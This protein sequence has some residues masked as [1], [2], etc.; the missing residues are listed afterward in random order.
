MKLLWIIS[1]GIG[2]VAETIPAYLNLKNKLGEENIDVRYMPQY[3]TDS[4]EKASFYPA[5]VEMITPD[6]VGYYFKQMK[7]KKRKMYDYV[8][9][10]PYVEDP[11]GSYVPE[12]LDNMREKDSEV[13]RNLRICDFFGAE[14]EMLKEH[15]IGKKYKIE[16]SEKK[17]VVL[18]NG[19]LT[20]GTWKK[21]KYPQFKELAKRLVAEG[22][23]VMS[24]GSSDEYI[25]GTKNHTGVCIDKTMSILEKA[26]FYIGTDTGTAHLAGL[27]GIQGLMLFTVTDEKKNWDAD[28]HKSLKPVFI[29][30]LE[31]R[32][33][34][35]GYHWVF[36]RNCE[37]EPAPCQFISV[38]K[39]IEESK[40]LQKK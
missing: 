21:K 11:T 16:K 39:I 34:Q 30:D 27:L 4:M 28:F 33:C 1:Q 24:I 18:H 19:G 37:Q 36:T 3:G 26:D 17:E 22:Y 6:I 5:R 35:R 10:V 12:V 13:Q 7:S 14:K 15:R 29:E 32:P 25:E 20:A 9:K 23:R 40:R 38:D 2:N 31:C 8:I